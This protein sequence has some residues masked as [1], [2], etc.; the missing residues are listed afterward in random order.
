MRNYLRALWQGNPVRVASV[1][2]AAVVAIAAKYGLILDE[3]S[4]GETVALVVPI[5]LGGE[6]ARSQVQ[7]YQGEIGTPSDE[8]LPPIPDAAP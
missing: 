8:L 6:V 1:I 2:T 3:A 7:P 4:V 5:L